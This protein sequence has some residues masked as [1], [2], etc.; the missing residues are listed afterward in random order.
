MDLASQCL[1]S[2]HSSNQVCRCLSNNLRCNQRCRCQCVDLECKDLLVAKDVKCL[3]QW[4]LLACNSPWICHNFKCPLSNSIH[5]SIQVCKVPWE[6]KEWHLH[7]VDHHNQCLSSSRSSNQVC[8]CPSNSSLKNRCNSSKCPSSNRSSNPS[9]IQ[10]CRCPSNNNNNPSQVD[11]HP[12][13][14]HSEILNRVPWN[15]LKQ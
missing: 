11:S 5:N 10:E 4:I 6:A 3:L 15:C 1:L 14:S 12:R 2:S 13:A 7:S 9:S 8:K